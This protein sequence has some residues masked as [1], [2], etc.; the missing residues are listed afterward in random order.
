MK[1]L[2]KNSIWKTIILSIELMFLQKKEEIDIENNYQYLNLILKAF[3]GT[4]LI[5]L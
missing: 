3:I 4:Q 1:T 2:D 5:Y